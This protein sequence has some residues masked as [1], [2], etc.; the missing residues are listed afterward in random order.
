MTVDTAHPTTAISLDWSDLRA[1]LG[2]RLLLSEEERAR[3]RSDFG[4]MVDRLPLAV[5]RC[6]DAEDVAAVVRFCRERG[7]PVMPRGQAHTQSGQATVQDGI[8]VDTSGM[9]TIHQ[10]DT[11]GPDGP[12]A[13]CDAG[14]IWRDLTAAALEKGL[15]PRVLTN[16][17]GV[18][19]GGTLSMAGLGVASFR[20]GT[21][22]DNALELQVVT[23][24]GEIVTCS[25]EAHRDL[26]DAVRCG[27]GQFGILTRAKVRLR[28]CKPSVRKYYL[29][30]DDL[31]LLMADV[32]R[33][34]RPD[35]PTFSSVE[36]WCTPC[37]QGI[38][39]IGEG[40]A[41]G[42]GMQTFAAWF[43]PVHLTVDLDAG[44]DP[45]TA[46]VLAGLSPY[47][48]VHTED[49]TQHEF[50][51][52]MDPV[53]ELWRRSGYW[54]MPHPW[55]ET[56]L[57]WDTSREYIEAALSITPPQALGPG[58]H[59]LLWP[60]YTHSSDVPL[61]MHPGG[62]FVMGWGILPA[63]PPAFLDRALAQLD[64]ASELSIHY[65]GKRYLSGYVTFKTAEQWAQHFGDR[66]PQVVA[67][68]RKF[69]PDG[70]LAPGFIQY[71]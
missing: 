35:N 26:F 12:S 71:E 31:G 65:G 50:V 10:I 19:L 59:I 11:E 21:Q 13:T 51:N 40:M 7:I 3:C 61:F 41:L 48:H 9:A 37:L 62:E 49:F 42:E 4:R 36:S 1:V 69:D 22:A 6:R 53:F 68:K 70:I 16:N 60:A 64:M 39:K 30:Y 67:A 23:G 58:G 55:M 45:D 44:E 33:V 63:V 18:S 29:L 46:A 57:P 52:R 38:K 47:R 27:L 34:M 20:Y 8:L 54:D 56:I 15:V 17:L 66:W 25:R 32:Q 28:A 14:V 2:D 43:Y 24:T 5:A